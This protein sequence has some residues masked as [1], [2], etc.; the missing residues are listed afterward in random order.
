MNLTYFKNLD[1]IRAIAALMVLV[2]HFF[3][4][5]SISYGI[6]QYPILSKITGL[7]QHGVTLFF[8]LSGFVIT[9]ILL[10]SI[11][12]KNYFSSFYKRRILRI[13]PLYYGSLVIYYVFAYYMNWNPNNN[14]IIPYFTYLQNLEWLTGVEGFGPNHFWS[15]AVEE[16]FYLFWPLLLFFIP[17]M[18]LRGTIIFLVLLAIPIKYLFFKLDIEIDY[19]SLTR[20][21]G[22]LIGALIAYFEINDLNKY[23]RYLGRYGWFILVIC[24]FTGAF[25]FNVQDKFPLLNALAKHPILNITFGIIISFLAFNY[26][27]SLISRILE[28]RILQYLGQISYGIY[29]WHMLVIFLM[30]LDFLH[31]NIW[32]I[33]LIICTSLTIIISHISYYYFELHFLKLKKA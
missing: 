16:H 13:F 27:E 29:V 21:D 2:R 8:V 28:T 15:L 23:K 12:N 24:L 26:K 31:S 6:N 33:D 19:N 11:N 18:H 3:H 20:Y 22:L 7:L 9:R 17:K 1:G 30:E 5:D 25:I 4:N 14:S 32:Y 10:N